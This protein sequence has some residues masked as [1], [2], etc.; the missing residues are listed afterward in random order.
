[1]AALHGHGAFGGHAGMA[2][3]VAAFHAGQAEAAGDFR[4]QAHAL[5]DLDALPGA[6]DAHVRGQFAQGLAGRRLAGVYLE[7]GSAGV[8]EP[9]QRAAQAPFQLAHQGRPGVVDVSGLKGQLD[10]AIGHFVAVDG[11]AGAVWATVGHGF[12]HGFEELAELGFQLGFFQVQ[13]YD[14][15]H[16]DAPY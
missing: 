4:R 9:V 5:E 6:H 12:E 1:M 7:H 8:L 2:D 15:T 13:T 3:D 14:S 10:P 11:K 16:D